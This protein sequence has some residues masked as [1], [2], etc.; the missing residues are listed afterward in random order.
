MLRDKRILA[1]DPYSSGFGYAILEGPEKLVDWGLKAGDDN[2]ECLHKA[3][4][5][6]LRYGPDLLVVEDT[7]ARGC[8]RR[9][10]AIRLI[11]SLLTLAASRQVQAR[12]ISLRSVRRCFDNG[13]KPVK[14]RI[15]LALVERFPE[16][17]PFYSPRKRGEGEDRLA[18]FDAVALGCACY[19][20]SRKWPF[21]IHHPNA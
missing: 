1:V 3:G 19:A 4:R 18:I 5:L 12:R 21:L 13:E 14:Q 6:I 10:R 8:Q 9:P 2:R 16:L 20:R 15:A 11:R 7:D 17:E